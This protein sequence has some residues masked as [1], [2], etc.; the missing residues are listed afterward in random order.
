MGSA[1][2]Q[3]A[4][5]E[6][7][8]AVDGEPVERHD[9]ATDRHTQSLKL[10]R[11]TLLSDLDVNRNFHVNSKLQ[12]NMNVSFTS[13]GSPLPPRPIKRAGFSCGFGKTAVGD[14]PFFQRALL[15]DRFLP[16]SRVAQSLQD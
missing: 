4:V 6:R 7:K 8:V 15:P 2:V 1:E 16:L 3:V 12:F 5:R 11:T 14:N 13:C 9:A 10:G